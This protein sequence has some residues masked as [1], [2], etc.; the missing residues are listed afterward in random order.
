MRTIEIIKN[1][2][3]KNCDVNVD[4]AMLS[5]ETPLGGDISFVRHLALRAIVDGAII[6]EEI[7][8]I[9]NV[10]RWIENNF[11]EELTSIFEDI[12]KSN[13]QNYYNQAYFDFQLCFFDGLIQ[14]AATPKSAKLESVDCNVNSIF[15]TEFISVTELMQI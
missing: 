9:A 7:G 1:Y 11:K 13:I 8:K 14:I 3:F 4:F 15:K 12:V 5:P 10:D 6:R 2:E